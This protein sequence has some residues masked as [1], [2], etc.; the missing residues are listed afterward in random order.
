[1]IVDKLD[2][3]GIIIIKDCD[4]KATEKHMHKKDTE[5]LNVFKGRMKGNKKTREK[6]HKMIKLASNIII[7]C[8]NEYI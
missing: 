3:Q 5:M 1:M 8:I 6:A 2:E 4:G 7:P